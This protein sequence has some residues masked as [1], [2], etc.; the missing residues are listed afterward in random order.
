MAKVGR[1]VRAATRVRKAGTK[2]ASRIARS[3]TVAS[4]KKRGLAVGKRAAALA[5]R[6][7][8]DVADEVSGRTQ[9][10]RTR[11]KVAAAVVGAAAVAAA[12][13]VARTRAAGRKKKS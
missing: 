4:A 3:K 8:K 6:V 7:R 13:A 2:L 1:A 12:A 11:A 10:R 5:R 9:R